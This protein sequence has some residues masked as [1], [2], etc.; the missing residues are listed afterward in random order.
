MAY[1]RQKF[2][3]AIW[4]HVTFFCNPSAQNALW[5]QVRKPLRKPKHPSMGCRK[6][7][8]KNQAQY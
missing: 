8:F 4:R 1:L 3:L 2:H 6:V 7:F 5:Q